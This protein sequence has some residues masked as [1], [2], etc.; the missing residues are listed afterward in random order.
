MPNLLGNPH[1]ISVQGLCTMLIASIHSPMDA[2]CNLHLQRSR[3]KL[4]LIRN[5]QL[6]VTICLPVRLIFSKEVIRP[7]VPLRPPCYDFS[8]LA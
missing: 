8:P 4:H 2:H 5:D 6:T 3:W 7:Q 1:S